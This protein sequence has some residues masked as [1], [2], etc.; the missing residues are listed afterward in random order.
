MIDSKML[1]TAVATF[2]VL[3]ETSPEERQS[4]LRSSKVVRVA[5]GDNLFKQGEVCRLFPLLLGGCIRVYREDPHGRQITLYDVT[6][7]EICV[8]SSAALLAGSPYSAS[9]CARAD[10]VLI[11]LGSGVFQRLIETSG[12]WRQLVF[13]LYA[14][15]FCDLTL[16]VDEIAFRSLSGRLA[17]FLAGTP[18]EVLSATH[19]QM[20][21]ELGSVRVIITRLL[22]RF[23]EQGWIA[24]ERGLVTICNRKALLEFAA[25]QEAL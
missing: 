14:E 21:D 16:L 4:L 8:L 13:G 22:G 5:G 3:S 15:R 10:T 19:Q 7:G 12:S 24:L 1:K 18:R 11:A 2:P 20:A 17:G 6:P 25:Q 23:E 9:A